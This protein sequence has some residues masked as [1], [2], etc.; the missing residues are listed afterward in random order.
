MIAF[1]RA[2]F[3]LREFDERFVV[4]GQRAD[5][6]SAVGGER[7]LELQHDEGVLFADGIFFFARRRAAASA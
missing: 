1:Q 7:I 3:L 5:F 2:A 6:L 4:I